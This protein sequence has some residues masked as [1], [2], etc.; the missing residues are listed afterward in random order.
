MFRAKTPMTRMLA[1]VAL[2]FGL[3]FGWY[4][5]KKLVI[6]W[7]MS[8]YHPPAAT[9]STSVAKPQTWQNYLTAVGSLAAVNGVELSSETS[10]TIKEIRFN[11]GQMVKQGDV[12]LLMDT[13]LEEA[14]LKN[15]QANFTLAKLNYDRNKTLFGKNASSQAALD[16]S[17]AQL[18]EAEANVQSTQAKINYKTI[19]APFD[20]R[21]GIREVNLGQTVSPG[22]PMVTLQSLNPLYVNLTV[23]EQYLSNLYINQPVEVDVDLGNGLKVTG[24]ITAINSKVDESTRNVTVQATI[25]N[26]NLKLYP[27]MFAVCKVWLPARANTLVIPQT[28]IT[29]SLSGDYVFVVKNTAKKGKTPDYVATRAFIKVGDRRDTAVAVLDGLQTGDQVITSG[30]LKIQNGTHV[31]ID[32]HVEL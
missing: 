17:L 6:G 19:T 23:P 16:S 32:N 2:F 26:N 29:Y 3:L 14:E 7:F 24:N 18:Q 8:H 15:N 22:T 9:I 28:A 12:I 27:G 10:G 4:G 5:L 1:Y 30:Q 31:K 13:S 20:G 21:L 11:S 25:P